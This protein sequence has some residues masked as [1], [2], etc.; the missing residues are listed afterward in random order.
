MGGGAGD[1]SAGRRLVRPGRS[2]SPFQLNRSGLAGTIQKERVGRALATHSWRAESNHRLV[3]TRAPGFG[4]RAR[5][6]AAGAAA[7]PRIATAS[8]QLSVYPRAIPG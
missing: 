1:A 8:F 5:R 4:A 3:P 6:T 2:R 7:L